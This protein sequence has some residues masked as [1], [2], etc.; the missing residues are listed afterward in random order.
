MRG[1]AKIGNKQIHSNFM[2]YSE[3]ERMKE[4][5]EFAWL[6]VNELVHPITVLTFIHIK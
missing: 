3:S 2:I 4:I 6:V 1:G 5:D